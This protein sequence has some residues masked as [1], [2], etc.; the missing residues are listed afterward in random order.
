MTLFS[1][2]EVQELLRR[3]EDQFREF[4]SL[5]D[6]DVMPQRLLSRRQVRDWIAKYVAAFANADGGLLFLGVEND[7]TPSG[8]AYAEEAIRDFLAVS[9]RRLRP[10][11]VIRFQRTTLNA[12]EI[13]IIEVPM[14][15]EAVMVE[16]D[17]F[18]YRVGDQ[19]VLE[20]QAAINA[21]KQAYRRVGY[22][23]QRRQDALVADLDL[24][25]AASF[26]AKSPVSGRPIEDQLKYYG[27]LVD[28]P[29]VV[30]ITNAALLLFGKPPFS[31]WHPRAGIRLFRVHGTDRRHG[32]D[33]NVVQLER[34][35]PPLARMMEEA[36]MVVGR[37]IRKSERL[38]NLFFREMPEY[39][40]FAW[41]EAL[42]NAIA[43]RDYNDQGR[44]IEVAL[45]EDR[46]EIL[47][48]GDLI[49]PVT[50]EALARRQRIHA[51]RNPLLVRV[52]ADVGIMREEGEGIPRMHEEMEESLLHPPRFDVENAAFKVTL[53]NEPRF[54]G[55]TVEW[56]AIVDQQELFLNQKRALLAYPDGFAN[57]AYRSVNTL[58][59]DQ[60]YREIMDM[61]SRGILLP[62]SAPG[63]GAFYRVS[64]NLTKARD[65]L[66]ERI[67]MLQSFFLGH[68]VMKNSHYREMFGVTRVKALR[69][70][71]R[72]T[73]EG[74]LNRTGRRKGTIYAPGPRFRPSE[75][76]RI[77]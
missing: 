75:K 61:V 77:W 22:E 46:M 8:H 9:T 26:L 1:G 44:E 29:D 3:E 72:L 74:I 58:D 56:K 31:R 39:P 71:R 13:I 33:R 4:K 11:V 63:R 49:P 51:S 6:R 54:D 50:L 30:G 40:N 62:A 37:Q 14:F 21:R 35:E 76:R 20:A 7:G 5:W 2:N 64:P 67:P 43:H 73:E 47:S 53:L 42:V 27:L 36:H 45:F 32:K 19:V 55:A 48:A 24:E 17:G 59:R 60:A 66:A 57:E 16:G 28:R 41:Q 10:E 68:P 70:L 15:P 69:E 12:Q 65:W 23:Q 38:H 52:L 18:P 25:L 34:L